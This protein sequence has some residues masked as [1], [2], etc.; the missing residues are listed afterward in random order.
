LDCGKT[1]INNIINILEKTQ[2]I[3]HSEVMV[4]LL[5]KSKNHRNIILQHQVSETA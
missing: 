3:F 4:E 1:T 5:R 2:L